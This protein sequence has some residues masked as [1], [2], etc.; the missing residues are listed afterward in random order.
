MLRHASRSITVK[1]S[2]FSYSL[3]RQR[4]LH[5]APFARFQI[6]RMLFDLLD[7]VLLLHFT[8]EAAQSVFERL[9]FLKPNF[10]QSRHT[11]FLY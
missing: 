9:T 5:T 1:T 8:L 6:V 3:A 4:F 11:P 2:L 7:D 10:S